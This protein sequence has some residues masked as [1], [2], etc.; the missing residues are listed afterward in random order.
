MLCRLGKEEGV[1]LLMD[2]CKWKAT[3]QSMEDYS[4]WLDTFTYLRDE[5]AVIALRPF[6]EVIE[7]HYLGN[8]DST[9]KQWIRS[10]KGLLEFVDVPICTYITDKDQ[11]LI[12]LLVK[13]FGF[14]TE[15]KGIDAASGEKIFL[16][17]G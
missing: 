4:D 10:M 16:L 7:F 11:R 1:A 17:A 9:V 6:D 8:P 14:T 3:N 13:R 5:A 12:D 2:S 15:Y